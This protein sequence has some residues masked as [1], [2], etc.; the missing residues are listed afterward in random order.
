MI[1]KQKY[2]RLKVNEQLHKII[3]NGNACVL[4]EDTRK[5]RYYHNTAFNCN[6]E[7]YNFGRYL[8]IDPHIGFY[9]FR[10]ITSPDI[11]IIDIDHLVEETTETHEI[12]VSFWHW[13]K[14]KLKIG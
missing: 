3:M 9:Y 8:A 1:I 12:E 7:Y 14:Y 5:F 2:N 13:I 4:M 10:I 6:L 11:P